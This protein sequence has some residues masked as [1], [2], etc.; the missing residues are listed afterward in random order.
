VLCA[1]PGAFSP[2]GENWEP[3]AALKTKTK[4]TGGEPHA[5]WLA[6]FYCS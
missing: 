1:L 5:V 3:Q 4:P 2:I 6:T